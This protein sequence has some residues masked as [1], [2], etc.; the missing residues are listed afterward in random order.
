LI[1]L[2][3]TVMTYL[4]H[5]MR[6]QHEKMCS[7]VVATL[8][9]AALLLAVGATAVP[10]F[11]QDTNAAPN[12]PKQTRE[13]QQNVKIPPLSKEKQP[14]ASTPVC[15][16]SCGMTISE[17]FFCVTECEPKAPIVIYKPDGGVKKLM[18]TDSGDTIP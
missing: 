3:L 6:I 1:R 7:V 5:Y 16:T 4:L 14:K 12:D 18:P 11:G 17:K 10:N 13:K 15:D 2:F 9:G 8:I